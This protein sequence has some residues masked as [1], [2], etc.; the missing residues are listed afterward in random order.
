[1][2]TLIGSAKS[3]AF[4]VMWLLEELGEPYQH[5]D[6]APRSEE[7]MKVNPTG[8]IPAFKDGDAV[9]LDSTA[10][11]QYLA[12]KHGRF[13]HPAG[14]IE[15]A[16]QDSFTQLALDDLDASC[17]SAAKH[18]FVL[19]ETLRREG[20]EPSFRYHFDLA[21]GVIEERLKDRP[22]LA[23]DELTVADIIT[24]HCLGWG[25]G[26]FGWETPEGRL[27]EYLA[28]CRERPAFKTA[29]A[30]REAS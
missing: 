26:M 24:A 10:I 13:T 17:W 9:I 15:R 1:M 7:A 23:G 12:D 18:R 28:R 19:P 4:R 27:S 5:I 3:R 16:Q 6:A 2:Y 20:L 8:R 29:W 30:K 21:L 14:T 11:C 22:Y 25:A